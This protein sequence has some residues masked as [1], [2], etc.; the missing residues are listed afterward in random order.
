MHTYSILTGHLNQMCP[1]WDTLDE[2]FS[3]KV[4]LTPIALY[5]SDSHAFKNDINDDAMN[6][7]ELIIDDTVQL[8]FI[9]DNETTFSSVASAN[10]SQNAFEVLSQSGTSQNCSDQS[11]SQSA[12]KDRL[13]R[14]PRANANNSTA[15]LYEISKM[16][17]ETTQKKLDLD[18]RRLDLEEK[19]MERDYE[20]R[21]LEAEAR[22]LEA[23][24][25]RLQLTQRSSVNDK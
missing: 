19:K 3:Q 14:K 20:I 4:N 10:E 24:N 17:N 12:M 18:A 21:K 16:R 9:D 25:M 6:D 2:I 11:D 8:D 13:G 1:L 22:K 5:E 23:E 15:L 7:A